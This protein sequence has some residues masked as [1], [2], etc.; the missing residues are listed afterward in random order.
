MA[1]GR[2]KAQADTLRRTR[3]DAQAKKLLPNGETQIVSATE[4]RRGDLVLVEAGDLIPGDGD[5]VEGVASVNEA[6]ITGESAPVIKEPGTDIR[7]SVTGGTTIVSDYL[8]IRI[9]ANP[10]E[11]FIDR[12]IALVEG[13]NRQKTPNEIALNILLASLTIIFLL[14]VYTLQPFAIYSGS[15][16]AVTTLVALLVCLIPTTIGGLLSAIGIAGMDRLVQFNVL[17]MSGRAVEAAGDVDTLLL[18]KTGTITFGNRLAFQF[19]PVGG[20]SESGAD[21]GGAPLQPGRRDAGGQEHR[22]AGGS[23][24]AFTSTGTAL[25]GAELV[26]FT[27]ETRMSGIKLNGDQIMKGAVDAIQRITPNA[28]PGACQRRPIALH[29]RAARRSRWLTTVR[30]SA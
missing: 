15:A 7:S 14:A 20:H 28:P 3:T 26:P 27:A 30:R 18:D 9:T 2:G 8:K 1:E 22:G 12:M 5:V 19:V 23:R 6:A 10:G 11:T 13:A 24:R 29:A 25:Q 17:A 16:V 4:L 21:R